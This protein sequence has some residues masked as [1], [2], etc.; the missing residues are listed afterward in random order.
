MKGLASGQE[1]STELILKCKEGRQDAWRELYD[2]HKLDVFR[3]AVAVHGDRQEAE[4]ITQD[5]F[6]KVFSSLDRFQ[7]DASMFRA[8]LRRMTINTCISYFRKRKSKRL[9]YSDSI[10]TDQNEDG[11]DGAQA[12]EGALSILVRRALHSLKAEL[13]ETLILHD[14]CGYKYSEIG[15]IMSVKEGTVK[16]RLSEARLRMRRELAPYRVLLSERMV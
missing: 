1:T 10:E 2:L 4:D 5:V 3:L 16:S 15:S 9:S 11:Q 12:G 6:V 14:V 8:W 13:R 7:G